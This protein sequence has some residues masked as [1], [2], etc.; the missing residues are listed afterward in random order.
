MAT[1]FNYNDGGR[2]AAGYK[3]HT[4]DCVC[5]AICIVTG[6][7]YQEVYDFLANGNAKQKRSKHKKARGKTAAR[8]INTKR[9]WFSDYMAS[10][11]F[12]CTPTMFVGQGCKV[13]LCAE[14]LPPGKLIVAVSKHW[15]TVIDGVIN[16][17]YNPQRGGGSWIK[18]ENGVQTRGTTPERCVYGYYTL[19]MIE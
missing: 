15:T 16:D 9:K 14:E 13:H 11:G 3:G 18:W 4:G 7:P 5:R 17:T 19:K 12:V 8:G 6:K 1:K 10:L 2:A